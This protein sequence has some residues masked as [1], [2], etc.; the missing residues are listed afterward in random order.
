MTEEIQT[1]PFV[2][3]N[4]RL[5]Q[6]GANATATAAIWDALN[7]FSGTWNSST[8]WDRDQLQVVIDKQDGLGSRLVG[9]RAMFTNGAVQTLWQAQDAP[10]PP[11]PGEDEGAEDEGQQFDP[12]ELPPPPE[13]APAPSGGGW[14][15]ARPSA[16]RT[17]HTQI[18][19][20]GLVDDEDQSEEA[21]DEDPGGRP[22]PTQPQTPW[23]EWVQLPASFDD[24][25]TTWQGLPQ[26]RE[27]ATSA[28]YGNDVEFLEAVFAYDQSP[29]QTSAVD[30]MGRFLLP[31][32]S[33]RIA[34]ADQ[35]ATDYQDATQFDAGL[36]AEA[37][38]ADRA[39]V[40][41]LWDPFVSAYQAHHGQ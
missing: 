20:R 18:G 3:L 16:G 40:A 33:Q 8:D 23:D 36:F 12:G 39:H 4:N 9:V 35:I 38:Q 13:D 15:A 17:Q 19:V 28:G 26:F 29:S 25:W 24:M 34:V 2:E 21:Q 27:Y 11:P 41:G 5:Q 30:V 6:H 10:P 31:D 22:A 32:S 1:I 7:A 14:A 37:E